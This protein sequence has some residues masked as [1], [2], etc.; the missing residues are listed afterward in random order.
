MSRLMIESLEGRELMSAGG[1][2]GEGAGPVTS[3][4]ISFSKIN[5]EFTPPIGSN[6][7]SIVDG[8]SNTVMF[9]EAVAGRSRLVETEGIF[10]F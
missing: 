5:L 1:L 10:Y 6:K 2:S 7:G 8:T 9:G 3:F 4:S